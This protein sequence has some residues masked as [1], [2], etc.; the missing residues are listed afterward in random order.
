[1]GSMFLAGARGPDARSNSRG[2]ERWTIDPETRSVAI[3]TIDAAP[4][5]FPR[6]DERLFGRPYRYAYAL[7]LPANAS[8]QF[9]GASRLYRHDLWEGSRQI[10]EFGE[11]RLPGEFVFVPIK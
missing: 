6:V 2:L 3:R 10:H 9:L 11:G 8:D 4:Q 7:A 5:E 1:M